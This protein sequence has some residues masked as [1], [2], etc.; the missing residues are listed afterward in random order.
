MAECDL[1]VR[2]HA[3]LRQH[4]LYASTVSD[5]DPDLTGL[6][7]VPLAVSLEMLAEVAVASVG[8]LVPIRLEQLRAYN[9]IALDDGP[10]TIRLEAAPLSDT[11]GHVRVS[12][13]IRDDAGMPLVE[14][15][16]VLAVAAQAPA[17]ADLEP[18]PL[19]DPQ[20]S[21]G[22]DEDLYLTGMFHGPLFQ[23]VASVAAWDASGMD[24]WLADTPLDG[25]FQPGERPN[26]LL[27]PVLLDAVGH[28]TAFWVG[29]YLG[30]NFS[31]F[32]SSIATID[33]YDA[34]REDTQG[35]FIARR[36]G[37]E[38][39]SA[40][41][42]YLYG[43][44]T[45]FGPDGSPLFRATG[46]RDRFFEVPPRFFF[47]RFQPRD[48]FYGDDVS[49][50]FANLP[51]NALV[52]RVPAFA[53]GFLDDAGG[54]WR[55][56]LSNT[57]LSAEERQDWKAL[58]R[59]AAAPRR[60]ADR[61]H[62]HQ[63][64]GADLDRGHV[65]RA[66]DASRYRGEGRRRRQALCLGRGTGNDRRNAGSLDGACRRRS[67]CHC[68]TARRTCRHRSGYGRADC[69]GDL[70]AAGF[71]ASEQAILMDSDTAAPLRVLLAW[72]A[73]EAAAKCVGSGL[74]GQPR[75]FVVSALDDQQGWSQVIVPGDIA[76]SVSLAVDDQSVLAVAYAD[77]A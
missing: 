37:A 66:A 38:Q 41:P 28:V 9:W 30:T 42:S 17:P 2:R 39:S 73:K 67:R 20:P 62:R 48:G 36:L 23:S 77:Q 47:A 70:L 54:I 26:F 1:D 60:M 33:L 74:N 29:Q 34:G 40:E 18:A 71:S 69:D 6:Q 27:N 63:G 75:S 15:V 25:F 35:S 45:C 4:C 72:C 49:G 51:D 65:R 16:V 24:A 8:G 21:I 3:F 76:L 59:A 53:R 61:T 55:R 50:L 68:G 12:A 64:G 43:E 52:W 5:L 22:R 31:C 56:V 32:P 11:D 10:R 58:S 13:R 19:S 7:V 14:A 44:F 57:V 46:W